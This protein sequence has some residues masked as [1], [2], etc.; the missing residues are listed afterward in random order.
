LLRKFHRRRNPMALLVTILGSRNKNKHSQFWYL[1]SQRYLQYKFRLKKDKPWVF[2]SKFRCR[3]I[4]MLLLLPI[5][6]KFTRAQLAHQIFFF[7][8]SRGVAGG[9][10]TKFEAQLAQLCWV[11]ESW[12][13]GYKPHL[14]QLGVRP[15]SLKFWNSFENSG[16]TKN[17]NQLWKLLK[18]ARSLKIW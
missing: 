9:F 13:F 2:L 6:G 3:R 16:V 15:H 17:W 8:L 1:T 18:N 4:L 10:W 7:H 12:N 14:S 11:L 5:C